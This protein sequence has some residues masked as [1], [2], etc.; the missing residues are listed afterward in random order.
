V[1]SSKTEPEYT[2]GAVAVK[3][4]IT[5]KYTLKDS[6]LNVFAAK[7]SPDGNYIASSYADGTVH[8]HTVF[9]GDR[10]FTP[11]ILKKKLDSHDPSKLRDQDLIK[12]IVT[13]ISWR[14][15]LIDDSA[16]QTFKAV[17]ADGMV[18]NWRAEK[19]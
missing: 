11:K 14:P 6:I 8:I 17:T 18:L 7:F 2:E 16:Y 13:S 5:H 19:A 9:K 4:V 10:V 1:N 3:A 12:P 15:A